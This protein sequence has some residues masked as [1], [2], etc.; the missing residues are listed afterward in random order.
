MEACIRSKHSSEE[1]TG[2]S[3]EGNYSEGFTEEFALGLFTNRCIGPWHIY[4][5]DKSKNIFSGRKSTSPF[6]NR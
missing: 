1:G 2:H 3:M 6:A 4:Q 5:M